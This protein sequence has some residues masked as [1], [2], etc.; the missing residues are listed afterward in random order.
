MLTP[1]CQIEERLPTWEMPPKDLEDSEGRL[2]RE[3]IGWK[4]E[5][6]KREEMEKERGTK[7]GI[8]RERGKCVGVYGWKRSCLDKE[9]LGAPV[10]P[11][12]KENVG[13]EGE[14]GSGRFAEGH[15]ETD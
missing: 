13:A 1:V 9:R 11:R 15:A 6:K 2:I 12:E 5:L 7:G 10:Y 4:R 14:E 3:R 8:S